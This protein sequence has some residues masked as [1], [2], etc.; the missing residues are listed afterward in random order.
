MTEIRIRVE[1][2]HRHWRVEVGLPD[3]SPYATVRADP[4]DVALEMAVPYI[5]Y[6]VEPDPFADL[7]NPAS[8]K[9]KP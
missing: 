8:S 2:E 6:A 5:A 9:E 7:L 1:R 4:L 3:G